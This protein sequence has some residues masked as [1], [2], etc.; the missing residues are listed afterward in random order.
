[1]YE[2]IVYYLFSSVT[3][4]LHIP[5]NKREAIHWGALPWLA[6]TIKAH[7]IWRRGTVTELY[8][9]LLEWQGTFLDPPTSHYTNGNEIVT[10]YHTYNSAHLSVSN[11]M[12]QLQCLIWLSNDCHWC[13]HPISTPNPSIVPTPG[14]ILG[15]GTSKKFNDILSVA[16]HLTCIKH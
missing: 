6:F 9:W 5:Q 15:V 12:D 7:C 10:C 11:A 4:N 3:L 8:D 1:M 16:N 14:A 2:N 13:P